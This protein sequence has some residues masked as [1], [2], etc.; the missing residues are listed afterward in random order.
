MMF[1]EIVVEPYFNEALAIE[2]D[3]FQFGFKV[4]VLCE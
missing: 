1:G 3:H 4:A 2:A